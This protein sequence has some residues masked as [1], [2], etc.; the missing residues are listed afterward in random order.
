MQ[1]EIDLQDRIRDEL[2][3][4]YNSKLADE[5]E[6]RKIQAKITNVDE[7]VQ[8]LGTI[9]SPS[10]QESFELIEVLLFNFLGA[11]TLLYCSGK[12]GLSIY[13][14]FHWFTVLLGLQ[15][16]CA[17]MEITSYHS[18]SSTEEKNDDPID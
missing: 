10:S 4:E 6:K 9:S 3:V 1:Q 7:K 8:A 14:S 16:C 15:Y 5:N 13:A 2:V 17:Q 11:L 12:C 18:N